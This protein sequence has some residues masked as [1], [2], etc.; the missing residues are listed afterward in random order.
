MICRGQIL[1]GVG[2]PD[3]LDGLALGAGMSE[4]WVWEGCKIRV[5]EDE[6]S[7]SDASTSLVLR[8]KE[9]GLP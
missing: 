4:M 1:G 9:E 8:G 3:M 5:W 6:G 7:P 2:I